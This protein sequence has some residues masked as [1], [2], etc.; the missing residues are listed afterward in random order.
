M[1]R[2]LC[3]VDSVRTFSHRTFQEQVVV[4]VAVV[5]VGVVV[6]LFRE[7]N[8]GILVRRFQMYWMYN[9]EY[10]SCSSSSILSL[11]LPSCLSFIFLVHFFFPSHFILL[12]FFLFFRFLVQFLTSFLLPF[13]ILILQFLSSNHTYSHHIFTILLPLT[14]SHTISS[15]YYCHS[16]SLT[17][18]LHHTAYTH[19]TPLLCCAWWPNWSGEFME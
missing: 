7:E 14:L 16:H 12:Y 17:P 6:K 13:F 3:A 4:V 1:K 15:P 11:L 19:S 5:V 10:F 18:Y 8:R 2:P 9:F